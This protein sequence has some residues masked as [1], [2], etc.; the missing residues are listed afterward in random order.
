M[1]QNH[2]GRIGNFQKSTCTRVCQQ[3]G[4]GIAIGG[5]ATNLAEHQKFPED[6]HKVFLS[7]KFNL[8]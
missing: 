5:S 8:E 2:T 3:R 4:N 1:W 6:Y 7:F